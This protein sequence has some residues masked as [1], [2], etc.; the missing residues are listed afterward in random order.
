MKR[1]PNYTNYSATTDGRVW[2]HNLRPGWLS[3]GVDKN[4]YVRY[5][6]TSDNG[7]RK[8]LYAHQAIAMTYL[9]NPG[10]KKFVNHLDHNKANNCLENLVWCTHLENIRHDWA[11][12]NR[13]VLTRGV[14]NGNNK[15]PE[16]LVKGIRKLY[17][18]G[19]YKQ[20]ELAERFN[21]P[22]STIHVIVKRKQWSNF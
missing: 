4:G 18:S 2:T 13:T 22:F 6:L 3:P 15:Y 17:D 1:I 16:S 12:G 9:P 7:K 11:T 5:S 14:A 10:N 8:G 19:K 20:V 21:M